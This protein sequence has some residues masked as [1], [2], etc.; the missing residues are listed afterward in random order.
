M[1]SLMVSLLLFLPFVVGFAISVYLEV[2]HTMRHKEALKGLATVLGVPYVPE[3][4]YPAYILRRLKE[5]FSY[6][7][8]KDIVAH[9][10]FGREGSCSRAAGMYKGLPLTVDSKLIKIKYVNMRY[11]RVRIPLENGIPYLCIKP[12]AWLHFG[13]DQ[14]FPKA[15]RRKYLVKGRPEHHSIF[16]DKFLSRVAEEKGLI[17]E[18]IPKGIT[19]MRQGLTADIEDLKDLVDLAVTLAGT[20]KG[21]SGSVAAA[22]ADTGERGKK[23]GD[24]KKDR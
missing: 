4:P 9:W 8:T 16:T 17:V 21:R 2:V 20:I 19:V 6:Q 15:F 13:V 11:T 18:V 24:R 1:D 7:A 12:R 5:G 10:P 3:E 14:R 23:D 22:G